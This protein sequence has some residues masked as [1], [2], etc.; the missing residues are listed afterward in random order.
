MMAPPEAESVQHDPQSVEIIAHRG[1]SLVQHENTLLAYE[2]AIDLGAD[3][4]E[5]D[6]RRLKD[7]VLVLHHDAGP[8]GVRLADMTS[9]EL[10]V[11]EERFGYRIPTL[12]DTLERYGDA[13]FWNIELKEAG[14]ERQVVEVITRFITPTRFVLTSFIDESIKLIRCSYPQIEAGLILGTDKPK[15][16]LITRL[17]E[18]YPMHRAGR[19]GASVLAVDVRLLRFGLLKN[20]RCF[21]GKVWVWTVNDHKSL[22]RLMMTPSI[23]G[24]FTDDVES[25]VRIRGEC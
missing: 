19:S 17:S 3:W 18:L 25:A 11:L 24:I 10:P 6:V 22:R 16:G 21:R 13:I 12:A 20:V 8:P 23:H 4:I 9:D 2:S 15:Y 5:V 14:Y 1:A 7:G